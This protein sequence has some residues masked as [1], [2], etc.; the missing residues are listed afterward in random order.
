MSQK[1]LK[2]ITGIHCKASV[3]GPLSFSIH[4][5]E[6][7]ELQL[8]SQAEHVLYADDLLIYKPVT[9]LDDF[10]ALQSDLCLLEW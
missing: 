5:D 10:A 2:H 4:I 1:R 8:S 7:T 6:V 3:L 9:Q